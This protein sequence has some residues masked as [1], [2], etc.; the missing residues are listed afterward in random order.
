MLAAGVIYLLA[1]VFAVQSWAQSW[2]TV[3]AVLVLIGFVV[4]V[5]GVIGQ[6]RH[7]A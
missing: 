4:W 3:G 5:V 2:D 6:R 1:L 7:P